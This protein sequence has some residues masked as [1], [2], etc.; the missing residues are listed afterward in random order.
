MYRDF[1]M[2]VD[3]VMQDSAMEKSVSNEALSPTSSQS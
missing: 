3:G 2:Q 1:G